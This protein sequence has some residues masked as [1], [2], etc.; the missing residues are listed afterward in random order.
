MAIPLIEN[1]HILL[2]RAASGFVP[3]HA[4]QAIPCKKEIDS[5]TESSPLR[6]GIELASNRSVGLEHSRYKTI[7][8]EDDKRSVNTVPSS[9]DWDGRAVPRTVWD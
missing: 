5:R 7:R 8:R 9:T 6:A 1:R 3:L 4:T 2:A